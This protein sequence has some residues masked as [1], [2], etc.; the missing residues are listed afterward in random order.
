MNRLYEAYN[1]FNELLNIPTPTSNMLS[2]FRGE[3]TGL[4]TSARTPETESESE[5][6]DETES[7]MD[8]ESEED[9]PSIEKHKSSRLS[10]ETG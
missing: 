3:E 8:E 4:V 10:A 2:E 6:E 7:E 1:S 5:M 9:Q